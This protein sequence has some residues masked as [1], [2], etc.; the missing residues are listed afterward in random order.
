MSGK[1]FAYVK[2]TCLNPVWLSLQ[3]SSGFFQVHLLAIIMLLNYFKI[4][5]R[6]LAKN[7]GYGFINIAG[8]AMGM[9]VAMLIGLWIFDELSYDRFHQNYG[10]IAQVMQHQT[11]NGQVGTQAAVPF[12]LGPELRRNYG[13]DFKYV[14]R[15]TWGGKHI[16]AYGDKKIAKNG[17]FIESDAPEMLTLNMVKGTRSG[18]KDPYSIIL[19]ESVARAFFG[20]KDPIDQI[21]KIDN[22]TDVKVTG[23]YADL[24]HNTSLREMQFMAPWDLFESISP[25]MKTSDD[26]WR[27]NSFQTFVQLNDQADIDK[28]S[29]KIKDVKVKN[30]H[31]EQLKYKPEVFLNPMQDWHLYSEFKQGKRVGGQI[32]FVWLF[33]VI[34]TFVLLLA[35]INF[36][37][38]STAR[39]E[40]RAK[41]VGVRKAIG[42]VRQQLVVQFF[43][44]SVVV[45]MLSFVLAVIL[46]LISLS[47]FNEVA[48]KKLHILWGNPFFWLAGISFSL[49]TAFIAGSYPAFYLSS[50]Q[51]VKVLKGTF[52][53][54]RFA[55]I[56][57]KALVVVQFTVSIILIIGTTVVFRQIQFAKNRPVGYDREGLL[58]IGL[59]TPDIHNHIEAVRDELKKSGAIIEMAESGSPTTESWSSTSGFAWKGKDPS[60]SVD[61]HFDEVSHGYGKAIGWKFLAGRDFSKEFASDSAGLVVN[62]AAVKFM[63]LKN[64]VGEQLT[65]NGAP[66][67]IIGV[68]KDMIVESPYAA[69]T[70]LFYSLATSEGGVMN[71]KLNPEANTVAALAEIETVF[72]KYDTAS[73]FEYRFVDETYAAKFFNEERIGKLTTFFSVLAILISCLGIF[74]LASFTAEQRTKEI[75][76][77]KVLGA[78]VANI[79]QML[80]KDF[81][82]LVLISCFISAPVAWYFLNGWLAKY[83]YRTEVSWWIFVTASVSTLIITLM[84]VSYQSVKAALINPVKSLKSE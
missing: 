1:L 66:L 30:I 14:V 38:L 49:L 81:V 27:A 21:M 64:P 65:W 8:L 17:P 6:N 28:V 53:A 16:L 33:G 75:G 76:V 24:P 67:Q 18:L 83:E 37:N 62:E 19:S 82:V 48:D 20:D 84:T 26:P 40:K 15:S 63:G 43:S 13:S 25:W 47:Q 77:R 4:A 58:V 51:P 23:V 7:K 11:Y 56:P 29:A 61:F 39:S 34:G 78:S 69:I 68:V 59:T 12:P 50:F 55:A 32:E 46:V 73:P 54:G 9:S 60:L 2:F 57:R 45:V 3:T 22:R 71:I 44:E 35:C 72:K 10:R 52:R 70:P 79:W 41:E 31:K 5:F 80:S 36:M 42:S 74:G